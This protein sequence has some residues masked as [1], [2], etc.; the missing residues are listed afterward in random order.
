MSLVPSLTETL[1]SWGL[2]DRLVGVTDWCTSPDL[3]GVARVR[4]T[5]NPD[6]A[7]I[8]LLRPDLVVANR[9][10]NRRVDVERLRESGVV[11]H[12]TAPDSLVQ[13]AASLRRLGAVVGAH[14]S[15]D[16]LADEI[17][18][19]VEVSVEPPLRTFCPVWRDPWISV[20]TGTI[21]GDLLRCAGFEVIPAIDRYPRVE[22]GAVRDL[23]PEVVLLPDEPYAFG[24]ADLAA[25]DGWS[26]AIRFVDGAALTWWG[27]RTAAAIEWFGALRRGIASA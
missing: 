7:E 5:K 20:G 4:G 10:E 14:E 16:R 1:A 13:V 17:E 12:V 19:A 6:L 21:A 22:L 11:V 24:P 15:A 27:P 3:P 8:G 9:E 25:F 26:A 23:E 2:A 18:S